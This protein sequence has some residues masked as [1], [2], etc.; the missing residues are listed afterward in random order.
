MI[1]SLLNS[2]FRPSPGDRAFKKCMAASRELGTAAVMFH[3]TLKMVGSDLRPDE[4][5]LDELGR[6]LLG[7]AEPEQTLNGVSVFLGC[8]IT[9]QLGGT[10][11]RAGGGYKIVGVV[12]DKSVVDLGTDIR[13][14][15]TGPMRLTP[16]AVYEK[17]QETVTSARL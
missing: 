16:R 2:I 1:G 9:E 7:S 4:S 10:W 13:G 17:I 5:A 15:L 12:A 14:P 6:I 8:I 11:E 3:E